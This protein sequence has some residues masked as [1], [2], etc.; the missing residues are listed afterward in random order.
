MLVSLNASLEPYN[1]SRSKKRHNN[2]RRMLCVVYFHCKT[3]RNVANITTNFEK[4]RSKISNFRP[5]KSDK[6]PAK[7][8]RDLYIYIYIYIY[9]SKR[10]ED[11]CCMGMQSC[12]TVIQKYF[13]DRLYSGFSELP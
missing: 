5:Q 6:S 2:I 3:I 10:D 13:G 4:S 12:K 9:M 8:W 11:A 1:G 7:S